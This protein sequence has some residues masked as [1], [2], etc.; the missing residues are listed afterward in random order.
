M[1]LHPSIYVLAFAL[2]FSPWF[3][4]IVVNSFGNIWKMSTEE[5]GDG[6]GDGDDDDAGDEQRVQVENNW[7][8]HIH[9][10]VEATSASSYFTCLFVFTNIALHCI[11]LNWI[12]LDAIKL[13]KRNFQIEFQLRFCLSER[14][15]VLCFE[16]L[17]INFRTRTERKTWYGDIPSEKSEARENM[18]E[19][20]TEK[21]SFKIECKSMKCKR[22]RTYTLR[23][24]NVFWFIGERTNKQIFK[25][26]HFL[27]MVNLSSNHFSRATY[28]PKEID[29]GIEIEFEFECWI[30]KLV[31]R[32][33]A[34]PTHPAKL[35]WN[36]RLLVMFCAQCAFNW[37]SRERKNTSKEIKHKNGEH[38]PLQCRKWH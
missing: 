26:E 23:G 7:K 16:R 35:D 38:K 4:S 1:L 33:F 6:D 34:L 13:N 30:L 19:D 21:Q 29:D 3:N 32:S 10:L 27:Q 15:P 24:F 18:A 20:R 9:N 2:F 37:K 31:R 22:I 8:K 14:F 25:F 5:C 17:L 36:F 12:E 28:T 11:S